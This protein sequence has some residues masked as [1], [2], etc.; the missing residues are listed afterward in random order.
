MIKQPFQNRLG[1][2]LRQERKSR[3]MTQLEL[4]RKAGV[5]VP[6]LRLLERGRGNIH[7]W[8][9]ALTTLS[10]CLRGRNLPQASSIGKQVA[11]LRKRRG[12]GQRALAELIRVTQPTIVQLERFNSGRLSTLDHALTVLGAGAALFPEGASPKFFT[13]A[14]N[15]ASDHGWR[16]P[17]ALLEALYR[18]FKRFDLDPCSPTSTRRQ[19]PVRARVHYT[20]DD[21]GL[22]LPWHGVVF[23]NPP[24][25][26]AI[27]QWIV[28]AKA[29]V[30]AG[31][32]RLALALV[33]ARTDTSWWHEGVAGSATVFFLR[34]RL[35]F[36]DSDQSA[37][38]PSALVVWGANPQQI[39]MLRAVLP[40]AWCLEAPEI[41]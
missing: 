10:L 17:K 9:K 41:F 25:G 7:S 20:L 2:L 40:D 5:S 15:S 12:L 33:P 37:P 6:T 16:T 11:L 35:S 29:E 13:H 28:K 22:S 32:A 26:R 38:F 27:G 24:Y 18:V 31:N 39:S 21:D 4:A 1:I 8:D 3:P 19:A 34:G 36:D 30:A 23:L 14:G